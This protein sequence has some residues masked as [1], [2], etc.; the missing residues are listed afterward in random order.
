VVI[1]AGVIAW[2]CARPAGSLTVT[3]ARALLAP[4]WAAIVSAT[5]FTT[6][7]ATAAETIANTDVNYWSGLA[8]A[9]SGAATTFVPGQPA[10]TDQVALSTS[11]TAFALTAGIGDDEVSWN[12]TVVVLVPHPPCPV[13]T[14]EPL[15]IQ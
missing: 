14:P 5:D 4:T 8:T 10:S 1:E 7:G 9:T 12:P 11:P 6:G 2:C 3:D 15:L 13:S